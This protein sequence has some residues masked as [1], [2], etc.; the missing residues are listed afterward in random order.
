MP[1]AYWDTSALVKR[2]VN[3]VGSPWV[4]QVMA[5]PAQQVLYTAILAQ[6]EVISA[7]QRKVRAGQHIR[8]TYTAVGRLPGLHEPEA[9][10]AFVIATSSS[11]LKPASS[12]SRS[13]VKNFL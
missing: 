5:R 1:P 13:F 7:F 3:E 10:V 2:Y 12:P 11:D 9:P 8:V 6:A 4:R